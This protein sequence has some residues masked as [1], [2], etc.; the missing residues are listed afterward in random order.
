MCC[1]IIIILLYCEND[2]VSKC[3]KSFVAIGFICEIDNY[4]YLYLSKDMK[5]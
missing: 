5:K 3:A 1:Q 4:F 2:S